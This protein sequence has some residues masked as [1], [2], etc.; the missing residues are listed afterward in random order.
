MT[1]ITSE[2]LLY[3]LRNVSPTAHKGVRGTL[4]VV[5]GS[6]MYRG[7]A[8]LAVGS[9]LRTGCGIVRLISCEKVVSAVAAR[10]SCCTF[11]PV[12]EASSGTVGADCASAIY[13]VS[14]KTDAFL[15]GCGLGQS[16]EASAAVSA[17]AACGKKAVLDADALNII[18]ANPN[19][20]STLKKGF[21]VTPHVGEM[22]RLMGATVS[23]IKSDPISYAKRFS[24]E[25]GCVTV[26]KDCQT[27]ISTENGEIY[28]SNLGNEGLAKGGSGDALAGLIAGFAA[29]D[30]SLA[31]AAIIGTAVHGLSAALCAEENGKMA[32]LPSDLEK[33][34]VKLLASL[35][36]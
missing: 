14:D 28:L 9:A 21:I 1:N 26:L 20:Y 25:H 4:T 19:I 3:K 23:D 35:G 32:M 34:T 27:V 11:L 33:Y 22:A 8:S 5:S 13:G 12:S 18:S 16:A 7:A 2:L 36:F 10:Y 17:V 15:I 31:D 29:Q 24:L 6:V 30:Y